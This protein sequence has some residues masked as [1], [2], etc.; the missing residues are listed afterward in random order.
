MA[1]SFETIQPIK[2][3]GKQCTPVVDAE[4]RLRLAALKGTTSEDD[5]KKA[6]EVIASCFPN[7]Q[8]YV[9]E[10]AL[11]LSPMDLATL[12]TYLLNGYSGIKAMEDTYARQVDK[13]IE[14]K[15]VLNG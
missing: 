10:K 3:D 8:E 4:A 11:G 14:S 15:G 2:L 5:I 13:I 6:A 12:R 1:L 9:A 7:E